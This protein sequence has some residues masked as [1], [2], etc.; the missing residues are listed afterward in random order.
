MDVLV[1]TRTATTLPICVIMRKIL[2]FQQSGTSLPLLMA[3][4]AADGI[5][6]TMKRTAAKACLQRP[7]HDQILTPKQLFDFES[8]EIDQRHTLR[9]CNLRGVQRGGNF[10]S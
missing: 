7:F 6:G 2:E 8:K 9:L 4:S 10:S 5:G 1:N 3:K